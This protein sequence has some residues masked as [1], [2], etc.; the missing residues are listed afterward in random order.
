MVGIYETN[1]N[2]LKTK[3]QDLKLTR[4]TK[5]KKKSLGALNVVQFSSVPLYGF[6]DY[7]QGGA[8]ISLMTAID[9]ELIQISPSQYKL[10]CFHIFICFI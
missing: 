2:E 10:I 9:V 5:S 8:E 1:L 7:L 6:L 4:K 3:P